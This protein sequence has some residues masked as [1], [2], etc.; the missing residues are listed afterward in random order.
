MTRI[1]KM[2]VYQ[3]CAERLNAKG[4]KP[5]SA[6]EWTTA[7]VQQTVYGKVNYPEVLEE[8][9]SIYNEHGVKV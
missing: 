6:R 2:N 4:I 1:K 3:Q 5:F 8:I 9:K 7:I